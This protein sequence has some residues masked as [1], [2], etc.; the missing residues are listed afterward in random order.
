MAKLQISC[1]V[2]PGCTVGEGPFWNK[3][4]GKLYWVD[5]LQNKIYRYDP[6]N[7][8]TDT[9]ST[10]EHIGF[11]VKGKK[12]LIG[13]LKS[14]LHHLVFND[15]GS[16]TVL[17]ID[18]VD[19]YSEHIRFNDAISDANG[20]IWA[21]T[22]DMRGSEP[23]GKYFY[24]DNN[25]ERKNIDD[26]YIVAN[27]PALS[28]DEKL[29]YTVETVGNAYLPRG[30]YVSGITSGKTPEN[31]RLL[32]DWSGKDTFPDGIITDALGNLWIGEFGGN[33]LR[34][35]WPN[36]EIKIEIPLPAWNITKAAFG[37]DRQDM[38]YV[39]SARLGVGKE[40]LS[41]YPD[42]GGIIQISNF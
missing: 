20:G 11:V 32:I 14:G 6:S 41:A 17:R 8:K 4:E 13:G 7:G 33:I 24:Y 10:P 42:T 28:P 9:W 27:G 5:I 23:L 2:N 18:R 25:L 35:F 12:N 40:I 15:D 22:M 21:C 29:L 3:N 36:G 31:K 38:I 30:V 34:C 19:E 26:G 39:T 16:L 37:N 1:V